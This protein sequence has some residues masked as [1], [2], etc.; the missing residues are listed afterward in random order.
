MKIKKI[1][2]LLVG[3]PI[4]LAAQSCQKYLDTTPDNR[5]EINSVDKVAQLVATAYPLYDYYTF[6][7]AAS[8]NAEDKGSGAGTITDVTAAPYFWNDVVGAEQGSPGNYWNGCYAGIASANQALQSI[9]ENDFGNA[10]LPYK[11]EALV[12]RAYAHFMLVTL[13]AKEYTIGAANDSPG[14]PYTTIPET[15][16]IQPYDRG[17]VAGVYEKVEKDLTEGIGLLSASAYSVPKFHFTPAAAH[18]FAARFYLFKGDWQK[19]VEHANAVVPGGDFS[20]I[21]RPIT[22]LFAMP[23]LEYQSA[24]TRADQKYNLLLAGQAS[25]FH[26]TYSARYGLGPYFK[27]IFD[28]NNNFT[29]KAYTNK[30]FT[31]GGEPNYTTGKYYEYAFF[32]NRAARIGITYIMAPLFTTDEALLNRAEAYAQLGEY[33]NALNDVNIILANSIRNYNSSDAATV[34]KLTKYYNTTD[35]KNAI[36][37]LILDIKRAQF[38][39]EGMRWLDILRHH[40]PVKHNFFDS[41]GVQTFETLEPGDPRRVFQIPEE[42]TLSGVPLNPR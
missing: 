5:A 25:R 17:T 15:K 41:N 37:K 38:L 34:E 6:T 20:N 31:I 10:V 29:K 27:E 7:E 33:N 26:K 39:Q 40:L 42:A 30:N 1:A 12:A 16:V 22:T 19:V 18:A 36:I 14:V 23:P 28:Y 24:F 35:P 13:F 21:V 9:E 2:F 11:G 32:V 4:L 3:L 8:D